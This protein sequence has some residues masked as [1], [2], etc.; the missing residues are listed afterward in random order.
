MLRMMRP[1]RRHVSEPDTVL[2]LT[3]A[4]ARST[5]EMSRNLTRESLARFAISRVDSGRASERASESIMGDANGGWLW[6]GRPEG[7][8]NRERRIQWILVNGQAEEVNILG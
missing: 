4:V 3:V 8:T 1:M 2:T 7:P 6:H 5:A